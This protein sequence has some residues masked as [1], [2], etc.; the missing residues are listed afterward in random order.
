MLKLEIPNVG[1]N[2]SD[3][4]GSLLLTH[5]RRRGI[6]PAEVRGNP[7]PGHKNSP[8]R[9]FSL[10]SAVESG[11]KADSNMMRPRILR[12]EES[13]LLAPLSR[14][15]VYRRR[16]GRGADSPSEPGEGHGTG[17]PRLFDNH[18]GNTF[19]YTDAIL[20]VMSEE[21][22]EGEPGSTSRTS[23]NQNI[24][25]GKQNSF[26][27]V[28]EIRVEG[29]LN[30]SHEVQQEIDQSASE[31]PIEDPTNL[32]GR[33]QFYKLLLRFLPIQNEDFNLAFGS[34][35]LVGLLM[36]GLYIL[37]V[38]PESYQYSLPWTLPAWTL[39]IGL[40]LAAIGIGYFSVREGSYC[41]E[42]ETPFALVTTETVKY[43]EASTDQFIRG[44]QSWE[45]Q[46]CDYTETEDGKKWPT[47]KSEGQRY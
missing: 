5:E 29:S 42:C 21:H 40:F 45:C 44:R 3:Q 47:D 16:I 25:E 18:T 33:V 15:T 22:E 26:E 31:V 24:N 19:M 17:L 9:Q 1:A 39:V 11:L 30:L 6:A 4:D 35:S 12:S 2:P 28:G 27:N 13:A 32:N 46:Y 10:I 14:M 20:N 41:P 7:G 23:E 43:P 36:V 8:Q 38:L 37:G 34:S